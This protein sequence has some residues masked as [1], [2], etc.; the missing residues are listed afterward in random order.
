MSLNTISNTQ[1][2]RHDVA[3]TA[4]GVW[5]PKN[6]PTCVRVFSDRNIL[7][8]VGTGAVADEE[9]SFPVAERVGEFFSVP[10]QATI[11][12]ITVPG[13]PSGSVW[14]TEV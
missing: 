5:T 4:V 8:S 13:E 1:S 9:T 11:S 14:I 2:T 3:G 10:A 12:A 6:T 7:I